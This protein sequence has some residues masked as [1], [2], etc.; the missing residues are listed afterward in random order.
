MKATMV[1]LLGSDTFIHVREGE[2][3]I[4]IR[5]SL[6]RMARAGDRIT[7]SFPAAACHLFDANGQ[8]V[9]RDMKNPQE[10]GPGRIN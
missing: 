9:S 3:T 10:T 6:G 4:T 8:R 5:D 7:V 1:E 2:E